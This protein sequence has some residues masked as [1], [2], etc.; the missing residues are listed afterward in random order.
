MRDVDRWRW[1]ARSGSLEGSTVLSV[2]TDF[3]LARDYDALTAELTEARDVIAEYRRE[4]DK[5]DCAQARI[6]KLE[7]ALDWALDHTKGPETEPT[8]L[9]EILNASRSR[10]LGAVKPAGDQ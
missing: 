8:E 9:S 2:N 6:R 10:L 7:A 4:E 5:Y 1:H 3:V